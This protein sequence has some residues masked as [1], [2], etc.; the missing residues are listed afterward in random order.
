MLLLVV[1]MVVRTAETEVRMMMVEVERVFA[2][3][4]LG[5]RQ[6]HRRTAITLKR[7]ER[8]CG[9]ERWGG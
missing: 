2:V 7:G 4:T 8:G 3:V 6:M 5:I 9:G 1:G